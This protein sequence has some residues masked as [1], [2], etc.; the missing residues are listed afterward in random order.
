MEESDDY[1]SIM[2][3]LADTY[4]GI[5]ESMKSLEIYSRL[6]LFPSIKNAAHSQIW[7]KY[8][9]LLLK[10]K[11]DEETIAKIEEIVNM[12]PDLIDL[13]TELSSIY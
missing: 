6:I 10:L 7:E 2:K 1:I 11:Q 3:K 8:G 12:F 4:E 13:Q 9:M 5:K